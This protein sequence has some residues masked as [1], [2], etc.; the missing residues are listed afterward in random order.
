MHSNTINTSLG[1]ELET[2]DASSGSI[3]VPSEKYV[4][5]SWRL[6]DLGEVDG[7]VMTNLYEAVGMAV[8][9]GEFPN[10]LILNHP[11]RNA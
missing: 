6:L 10:T 11:L 7:Y 3:I 1:E 9:R 4:G 5:L 8:S 2:M